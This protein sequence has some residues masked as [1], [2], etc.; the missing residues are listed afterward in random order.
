M[1]TNVSERESREVAEAARESEWKLA[2]FGKELF[3]GNF[4]LDLIHPQPRQEDAATEKGERF[5]AALRSFLA[6][7]VDPLHIERDARIPDAVLNGLKEL[8]ALGMKVPE[9][10]G[11][12]GLSQVYYNRALAL[13]GSMPASLSTLLSAHQ[14]IGV[15]EPLLLFGTEEQKQRWLPLVART[16]VSAFLL[17]EPDVGSDPARLGATATPTEDGSG[18]LL[19]GTKLWAT[20]GAIAD[21]V[22]VMAKVPE[23]GITAFVLPYDTDGVKVEHRNAFMGLRGIENSVTTFDDVLVPAENV[24]GK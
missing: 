7:D 15:A 11:G 13:A 5:L 1:T 19:N 8:G 9:R 18:Y 6:R 2:S 17:T 24:I 20:N 10:T 22:V 12:L 4:R 23:G 21:I 14:S 16:H 3:L